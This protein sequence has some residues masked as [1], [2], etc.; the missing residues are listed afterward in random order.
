MARLSN[1]EKQLQEISMDLLNMPFS[2][3]YDENDIIT[4]NKIIKNVMKLSY[5]LGYQ[6]GMVELIKKYKN[7]MLK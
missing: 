5:Q 6:K 7:E 2:S 3:K 4:K 1:Y